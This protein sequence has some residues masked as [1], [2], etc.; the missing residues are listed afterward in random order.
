MIAR[1]S[2]RLS[3]WATS[4]IERSAMSTS[5]R[6]CASCEWTL[7]LDLVRRAQQPPQHRVLADDP[8]VLADVPDGG[9]ARRQQV[10]RGAAAGGVELPGLLEVLDEREGVDRLAAA[11]QLEHRRED[12]PVRLAVEVL[13]VEALVDDQRRERR[14]REQDRA[15]DGLLG[16]EV[17]RRGDGP[18][19]RAGAPWPLPW[20][21][22]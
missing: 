1:K 22:A 12:D 6:G 21:F 14:V 15:E 4:R 19:G 13:R 16:L 7:R 11:V 20:P 2:L 10:D 18:S 8:R 17:L 5:S 3:S 9:D